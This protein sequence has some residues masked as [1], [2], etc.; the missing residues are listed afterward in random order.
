MVDPWLTLL[1]ARVPGGHDPQEDP[2]VTGGVE[3]HERTPGVSL[4]R[5]LAAL[6]VPRAEHVLVDVH[7][8]ERIK[9]RG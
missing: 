7:L 4:A 8:N 9:E 5:V 1:G 3:G 6:G 2:A